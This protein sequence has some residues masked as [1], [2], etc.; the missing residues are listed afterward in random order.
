MLGVGPATAAVTAQAKGTEDA[1]KGGVIFLDPD[2]KEVNMCWVY[3]YRSFRLSSV[4]PKSCSVG[5][6]V[7]IIVYVG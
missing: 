4:D 6:F 2:C 3:I 5:Y 1:S 7:K